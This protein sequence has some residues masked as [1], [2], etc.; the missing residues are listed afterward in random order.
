MAVLAAAEHRT[1]DLR[2][3]PLSRCRAYVDNS[4]VGIAQEEVAAVVVTV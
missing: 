4:L 3:S 2:A 1:L